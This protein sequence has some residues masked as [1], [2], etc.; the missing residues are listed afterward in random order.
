MDFAVPEDYRVKMKW[1]LQMHEIT[2]KENCHMNT[3]DIKIFAKN[4]K[5]PKKSFCKLLESIT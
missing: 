1:K 2:V 5:E 3:D 4:E